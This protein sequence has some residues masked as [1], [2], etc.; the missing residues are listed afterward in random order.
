MYMYMTCT[1][2]LTPVIAVQIPIRVAG[3]S[4]CKTLQLKTCT[5]TSV[6]VYMYTEKQMLELTGEML[7]KPIFSYQMYALH[8]NLHYRNC[9]D[10]IALYRAMNLSFLFDIHTDIIDFSEVH[11]HVA[12]G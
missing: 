11:I 12:C 8:P 2:S 9:E 4:P 3:P 6:L 10:D 7:F 1:C 5:Y